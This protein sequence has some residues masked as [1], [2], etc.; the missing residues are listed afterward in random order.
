M[1]KAHRSSVVARRSGVER[2][3]GVA[4]LVLLGKVA[5]ADLGLQSQGWIVKAQIQTLKFDQDLTSKQF[6]L[7]SNEIFHLISYKY[8]KLGR[9]SFKINYFFN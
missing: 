9:C 3:D 7:K 8:F 4:E 2:E 1:K 6:K 5:G